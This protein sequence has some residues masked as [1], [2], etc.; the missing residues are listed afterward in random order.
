MLHS[1]VVY[2]LISVCLSGISIVLDLT[3]NF[4]G[5]ADWFSNVANL[6]ENLKVSIK[7][8]LQCI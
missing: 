5:S 4:K 7:Q 1:I 3:P 6:A 2:L 8:N